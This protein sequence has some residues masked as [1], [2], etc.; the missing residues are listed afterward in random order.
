MQSSQ[1]FGPSRITGDRFVGLVRD[2]R[3]GWTR[4]DRPSYAITTALGLVVPPDAGGRIDWLATVIY[5]EPRGVQRSQLLDDEAV[6]PPTR[7][8]PVTRRR[9]AGHEAVDPLRQDSQ[10]DRLALARKSPSASLPLDASGGRCRTARF[11]TGDV[12]VERFYPANELLDECE[13]LAG[14]ILV[15]AL[16][17]GHQRSSRPV[18]LFRPLRPGS[19]RSATTSGV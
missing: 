19:A 9:V 7:S 16:R 14:R 11:Q 3:T 1:L 8:Q 5:A 4:R 17:R 18:C 6:T 13:N 12:G 15:D 10:I 2:D